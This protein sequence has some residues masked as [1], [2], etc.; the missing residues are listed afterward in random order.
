MS[1]SVGEKRVRFKGGWW[2]MMLLLL[3]SHG[4]AQRLGIVG[5]AAPAWEVPVWMNLPEGMKGLEPGDLEGRVIYLFFFQSWCP[6]CH[7]HG[8]PSLQAVEERFRDN[9]E[10]VFAA[11]Q[12]VF[13]G[14]GTNTE[15]R[16]KDSVE[17]YGL[18][19]PVGH[20]AGEEGSSPGIMRRYRTGG[21]PW[22]VIIDRKGIVRFDGFSIEPSAAIE[23]VEKLLLE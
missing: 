10:V 22:T 12:T 9:R 20:V 14:H 2:L 23:V 21:T 5:R 13:E 3:A 6:G 15:Q 4:E 1:E 17:E 18:P 7:S 16:A 11:V 8:F 19:I